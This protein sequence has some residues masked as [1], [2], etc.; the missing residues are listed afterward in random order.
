MFFLNFLDEVIK[1]VLAML[2]TG[3]FVSGNISIISGELHDLE[4]F[5]WAEISV[6]FAIFRPFFVQKFKNTFKLLQNISDLFFLIFFWIL[7]Q[8]DDNV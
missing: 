5:F 1:N 2:E 8:V 3:G 7:K 6:F 4:N